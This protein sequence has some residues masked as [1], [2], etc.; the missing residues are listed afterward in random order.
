MQSETLKP[1]LA[2]DFI[3]SKIKFPCLVQPKID[4]VRALNQN[5][6]LVGRS[7][8]QF[9][10]KHVT[11]TFS[12]GIYSGFDGEMILDAN[13]AAP[14]LCRLTSGAMRRFEGKDIFTWWVFDYV[15]DSTINLPY[16]QRMQA[17]SEHL[18]TAVG[19]LDSRFIRVVPSVLVNNI[20]EL[21]AL[22][23]KHLNDGYEGSIIRDPLALYKSGRSDSKMQVWRVKRFLDSEFL[24]TRVNEGQHNANEAKVNELGRTERST[25]QENMQ[26][27]GLLGSFEGILCDDVLDQGVV[28]LK[29]GTSITVS[30]GNLT[31][32]ERKAVFENP[33]DYIGQVGKFKLFPKGTLDKPR[34]PTFI[35]LRNAED[36]S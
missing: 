19:M 4:G 12:K 23:E 28:I 18:R 2:R 34:F 25:H 17:L 16:T 15:T 21:N 32:S 30:P 10:N 8:K 11:E 22:D 6:K 13:P 35:S 9:T 26:P 14:N 33:D 7:L 1:M 24:I 20:Q 5:G 27:N 31:A 3:E 36:I 29:K